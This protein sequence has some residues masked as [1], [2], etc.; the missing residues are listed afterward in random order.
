M[1]YKWAIDLLLNKYPS[2]IKTGEVIAE[3][4]SRDALDAI[5]LSKRLDGMVY[6]FEPD[7]I[8]SAVCKENIKE[9]GAGLKAKLYEI[10]LCAGNEEIEFLSIDPDLYD[11]RGASSMFPINFN[12]RTATDPDHRWGSVQKIV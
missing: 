3:I 2:L 5:G 1:N 9:K 4:G 6:V 8:N 7:P 12:N 11:N 10:A